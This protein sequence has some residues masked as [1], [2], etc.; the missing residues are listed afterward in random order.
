MA[1]ASENYFL[2][3]DL[4]FDLLACVLAPIWCVSTVAFKA[5]LPV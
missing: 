4:Y 3:L 1:N 5:G 2:P